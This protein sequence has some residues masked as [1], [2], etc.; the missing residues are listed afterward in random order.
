[1]ADEI[2][3]SDE[4]LRRAVV[5]LWQTNLLRR[6]K[7]TVLDEVYNGLSYYDYTFLRELPRLYCGLEDRLAALD[8]ACGGVELASFLR[9]GSW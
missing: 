8:P 1:T 9:I 4:Q 3:A 6:T 7:L 2:A 5:T